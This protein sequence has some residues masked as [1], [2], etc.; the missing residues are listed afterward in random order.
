MP[1]RKRRM[2]LQEIFRRYHRPEFISPDPLEFLLRYDDPL[3]REIVGLIASSLAYG[4]VSQIIKSVDGVLKKIGGFPRAFLEGAG[5]TMLKEIFSGFKHRFTTDSELV[6]LLLGAQRAVRRYGS[7]EA[8]FLAG[9]SR[10]DETT[11]PALSAFAREIRI[12]PGDGYSSLIPQPTKKSA[13]KRLHLFL[14][15]MVRSDEIDPGVWTGVSPAKLIVPLDTH[16]HRICRSLDMTSRAQADMRTAREITEGFRRI[17]PEDPVRYDFSLTR[18]GIRGEED[19]LP[20]ILERCTCP[21]GMRAQ[22]G[23]CYG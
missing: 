8:C 4:R 19:A 16:M 15:W 18:L 9:L 14:R 1:L 10:G 17:S 12:R 2:I 21:P 22:E 11:V 23:G 7:L 20:G 6:D 13:C 3:D 5:E